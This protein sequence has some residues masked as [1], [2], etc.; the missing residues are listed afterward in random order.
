MALTPSFSSARRNCNI[1]RLVTVGT[2]WNLIN[3]PRWVK[4]AVVLNS[5]ASAL[6]VSLDVDDGDAYSA[7]GNQYEVASGGNLTIPLGRSAGPKEFAV[8]DAA[9]GYAFVVMFVGEDRP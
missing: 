3:V 7:S 6:T 2:T 9:G 4:E 8:R 5:G 1:A